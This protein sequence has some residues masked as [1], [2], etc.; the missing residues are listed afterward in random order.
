M[1]LVLADGFKVFQLRRF[2]TQDDVLEKVPSMFLIL[3]GCYAVMQLIGCLLLRN[4]PSRE[5][6]FLRVDPASPHPGQL[7]LSPIL[8]R[9]V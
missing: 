1:R 2:F 6:L 5:V 9:F 7:E 8:K 4:P 3:G